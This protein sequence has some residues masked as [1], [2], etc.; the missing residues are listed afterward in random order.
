MNLNIFDGHRLKYY[1]SIGLLKSIKSILY[2][3]KN[4]SLWLY[5]K[6]NIFI[7][8]TEDNLESNNP[9]TLPIGIFSNIML[10]LHCIFDD[11]ERQ[12]DHLFFTKNYTIPFVINN[13]QTE[14]I[15]MYTKY[16]EINKDKPLHL[17]FNLPCGF[18][19]TVIATYISLVYN[20]KTIIIV[21]RKLLMLQWAKHFRKAGLNVYCSYKGPKHLM[22][23][24]N[25]NYSEESNLLDDPED[26][27][28]ENLDSEIMKLIQ[29]D[30][31]SQCDNDLIN[32]DILI[33]PSKHLKNEDFVKFAINNYTI[34]FI[35]ESHTYNLLNDSTMNR[36]L[37]NNYFKYLFSLSATPSRIN[38][39]FFCQ[40]IKLNDIYL[41]QFNNLKKLERKLFNVKTITKTNIPLSIEM[42]VQIKNMTKKIMIKNKLTTFKY[43]SIINLLY[44]DTNRNQIIINNII[45]NYKETTRGIIIVSLRSHL[46]YLFE[47][48]SKK[49]VQN[50]FLGKPEKIK[51]IVENI[52]KNNLKQYLIVAT[53]KLINTGFDMQNLNTLHI[54]SIF[55]NNT[56]YLQTVGR[57]ERETLFE[58]ELSKNERYMYIYNFHSYD[59]P[60]IN[61]YFK[62]KQSEFFNIAKT[63]D[64]L[65]IPMII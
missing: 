53:D 3:N 59:D 28:F 2:E 56:E 11:K 1:I 55:M 64:W 50:L 6:D 24:I 44:L 5:N 30:I 39:L 65:E 43:N 36:F 18:G 37:S 45:N 57:I 20:Y 34:C 27:E 40:E 14:V 62:Y 41:E 21:N 15:N 61:M 22:K 33:I 52:K 16:T 51:N 35:D 47:E 9:F 60:E 38:K 49:N 26:N 25:S 58:D 63:T 32:N 46:T 12:Y 8:V 19:K 31:S 42:L 10:K 29:E 13:L 4:G 48:L 17:T 23:I 54:A 7:E